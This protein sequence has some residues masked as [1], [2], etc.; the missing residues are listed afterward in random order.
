MEVTEKEGTPEDYDEHFKGIVGSEKLFKRPFNY[1][2]VISFLPSPE[3]IGDKYIVDIG[4]GF[5]RMAKFMRDAGYKKYL[6][7]DFAP[8]CIAHAEMEYPE[9]DFLLA[10]L[11]DPKTREMFQEYEFFVSNETLEHIDDERLVIKD[12]PIGSL[13]CF[14][15][16]DYDSTWHLRHFKN[17]NEI[18]AR[19]HKYL[20]IVD[21]D[22]YWPEDRP[23][24]AVQ[25]AIKSIRRDL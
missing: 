9:Y 8:V 21:S 20:D 17:V 1:E 11:K 12:L 14:T 25:F 7:I 19:Y 6:G 2:S 3:E 16:P 4:C 5:G 22:E 10:D 23:G 24:R 18:R 13:F 15:V